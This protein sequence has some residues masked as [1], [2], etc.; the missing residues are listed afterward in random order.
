[1]T[2][3]THKAAEHA[4]KTAAPSHQDR[5]RELL[6]LR[7]RG[8]TLG[9]RSVADVFELGN[10]LARVK[11]ILARRAFGPWIRSACG[12]SPATGLSYVAVHQRL[13]DYRGRL[14]QVS[15]TP[16]VLFVIA[17]ADDQAIERV[18]SALEAGRVLS[19]PEARV[20]TGVTAKHKAAIDAALSPEEE[21][22]QRKAEEKV[23]A[24][25]NRAFGGLVRSSASSPRGKRR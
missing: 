1:M 5:D 24:M 23:L 7:E 8:R 13:S 9:R 14:E 16:A 17:Y 15:V 19:A 25:L 20:M 22:R 4:A 6:G 11:S 21:E 2:K 3:H 10:C 18:V 12:V